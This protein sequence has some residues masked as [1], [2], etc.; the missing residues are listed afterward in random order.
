MAITKQKPIVNTQKEIRKE[1]KYSTKESH[2]IA[3]EVKTGRRNDQRGSTK[4]PEN[5]RQ[6][7]VKCIPYYFKY[8]QTKSSSQNT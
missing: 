2:Q 4:Q 7:G 6:N 8:K 3:W 1:S 5:N